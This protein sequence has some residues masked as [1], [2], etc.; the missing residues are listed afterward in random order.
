MIFT[1]TEL[2][3]HPIQFDVSYAPGELDLGS[4]IRQTTNLKATGSAQLLRNTLGEIRLRG[5]LQVELEGNCDRCLEPAKIELDMPFDLFYRPDAQAE[6]HGEVH[7]AE[8]EIDVSFYE[9]DGVEL[10][11][12]LREF[13]LLNTPMQLFCQ[14][15]CQG[16]CPECGVNRNEVKCDCHMEV[17]DERLAVLKRLSGDRELA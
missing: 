5:Q 11:L 15:D 12:A 9:G 10:E 7:L 1:I 17:L 14:E 3:H 16:L 2:E 6:S 13:V 4:E 8:G